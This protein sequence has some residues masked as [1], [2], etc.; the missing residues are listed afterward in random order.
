MVV[1]GAPASIGTIDIVAPNLGH[2]FYDEVVKLGAR[3]RTHPGV[4]MLVWCAESGLDPSATNP[5]GARGLNQMMPSTLAWLGAP[6]AFEK[7]SGVEQLPWIERFIAWV[8]TANHGPFTTAARYYVGNFWPAALA[9]PDAPNT[10][11]VDRDSVDTSEAAAYAANKGL[12]TNNDGKITQAD[13]A[14]HLARVRRNFDEDFAALD[15][16]IA[17]LDRSLVTWP[18]AEAVRAADDATRTRS[19]RDVAGFVASLALVAGCVVVTR[20]AGR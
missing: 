4:F 9:R 16:A 15:R 7:L 2:G 5:G 20:R 19:R 11:V 18:D 8:E 6:A 10:L 12:D 14:A 3:H 1:A 17:R 13:L